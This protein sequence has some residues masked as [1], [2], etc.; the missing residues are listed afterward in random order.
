MWIANR[1]L[2]SGPIC[3]ANKKS[4][5]YLKDRL[6]AGKRILLNFIGD[7]F[8]HHS[9]IKQRACI[10]HGGFTFCNLP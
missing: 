4:L 1:L 8:I 7:D 9:R 5:P 2:V 10:T 3:P 6:F